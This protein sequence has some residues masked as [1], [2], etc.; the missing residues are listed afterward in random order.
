MEYTKRFNFITEEMKQQVLAQVD[1]VIAGELEEV[2]IDAFRARDIYYYLAKKFN[3]NGMDECNTNGWEGDASYGLLINGRMYYISASAFDG[4][5][6]FNVSD[7]YDEDEDVSMG[8][9]NDSYD[10]TT[11]ED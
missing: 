9:R 10:G 2:E 5:V 11:E 7:L 6:R 8:D 3:I 4:G 1:R